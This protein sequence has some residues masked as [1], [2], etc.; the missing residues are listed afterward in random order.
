MEPHSE[1]IK[2][3]PLRRDIKTFAALSSCNGLNKRVK[4]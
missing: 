4:T 1:I 3:A 2:R